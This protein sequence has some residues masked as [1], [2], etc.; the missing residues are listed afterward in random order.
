MRARIKFRATLA[1]S[2]DPRRIRAARNIL[3]ENHKKNVTFFATIKATVE[4]TEPSNNT[5]VTVKCGNGY[6]RV[7][8]SIAKA[9]GYKW[10]Y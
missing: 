9:A 8:Y 1:G 7:E 3:E 6:V 10:S 2:S 5:I 4:I